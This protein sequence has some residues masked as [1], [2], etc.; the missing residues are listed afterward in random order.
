MK[1]A[2]EGNQKYNEDISKAT[3]RRIEKPLAMSIHKY[4]GCGD[5]LFFDCTE[6]NIDCVDLGTSDFDEAEEKAMEMLN[7]KFNSL[8]KRVENVLNAFNNKE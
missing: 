3:I 4:S 7:N 5:L 1:L 8:S 2:W 6:L